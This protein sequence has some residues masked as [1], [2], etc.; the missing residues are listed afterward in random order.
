[1]KC[2]L[3]REK[4]AVILLPE[5]KRADIKTPACEDCYLKWINKETK[6]ET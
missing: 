2:E 3:C 6:N 4:E 5:K 1:M